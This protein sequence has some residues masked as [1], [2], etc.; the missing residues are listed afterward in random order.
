MADLRDFAGKAGQRDRCAGRLEAT[1]GERAAKGARGK[2]LLAAARARKTLMSKTLSKRCCG[3]EDAVYAGA[4][5]Y[6]LC[7]VA[8]LDRERAS[9][10]GGNV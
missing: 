10:L 5:P 6:N 3:T 7:R 9:F 4:Y 2:G 8:T 1:A